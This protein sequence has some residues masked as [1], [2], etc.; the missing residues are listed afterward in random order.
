MTINDMIDA[1]IEIQGRTEIRRWNNEKE[2]YDIKTDIP[3]FELKETNKWLFDLEITYM[4][5]IDNTLVIEVK[6]QEE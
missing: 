2:N 1:G 6:E 4:Y 5:A 3:M